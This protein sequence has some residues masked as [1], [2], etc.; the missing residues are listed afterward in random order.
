[1]PIITSPVRKAGRA[2]EPD[3]MEICKQ[4][5]GENGQFSLSLPKVHDMVA[6]AFDGRGAIIGAVGAP[7]RIEGAILLLITQF[8][9]TEDWCLEEIFNYVRPEYRRTTHAKDMISFGKR[10]SDELNIPLVIG[11]VSNERTR[12][13]MELYRRQLGEPVGGYFLHRPASAGHQTA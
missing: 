8:W 3:I 1:M 7:D 6:R 11:V 2:D 5:H 12:A 10:C 13:K 4:N 9:Y